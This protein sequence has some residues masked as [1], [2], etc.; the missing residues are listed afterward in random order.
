MSISQP[1]SGAYQ[2]RREAGRELAQR[3]LRYRG[4]TDA[5]VLATSPES[6]PVADEI[7]VAL[8][9]PLDI[10]LLH[11][12]GVPGYEGVNMGWVAHDAYV[13][14]NAVLDHAGIS[15]QS[16]MAAA[17]SEQTDLDRQ[18]TYYRNGRPA[19]T[20]TRRTAIV[21]SEGLTKDSNLS[22]AIEVLRRHAPTKIVVAVPVAVPAVA[23]VVRKFV[24][25]L[26]SDRALNAKTALEAWYYAEG[27]EVDD[28]TVR[29]SLQHAAERRH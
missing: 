13:V 2:D 29:L 26:V 21:V 7:A 10:F 8:G 24:D 6:V 28:E 22:A 1:F 4:T 25:E 27:P 9:L 14:D 23:D 16:F 11:S 20:L 17:S 12:V 19:S 5:V 15:M 3:L 18:E